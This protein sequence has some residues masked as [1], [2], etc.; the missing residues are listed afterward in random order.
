MATLYR[1]SCV[2]N[3]RLLF[4]EAMH[5]AAIPPPISDEERARRRAQCGGVEPQIEPLVTRPGNREVTF[6]MNLVPRKANVDLSGYRQAATFDFTLD[7]AA[8]PI[9]PRVVR[10]AAVEVHL[11]TV[12]DD[13]FRAGMQGARVGGFPHSV[14]DTRDAEGRVNRNTLVLIGTV[15]EWENDHDDSS[16][17][18]RMTGRDLR[19]IL[20]DSPLHVEALRRLDST[21]GADIVDVVRQI[22]CFHPFGDEF[23][24]EANEAEWPGGRFPT[25]LTDSALPRH[26]RGARGNAAH[27]RAAHQPAAGQ[28]NGQELTYWDAI[29]RMCFLVGAIPYFEAA[30]LRIRPARSVFAQMRAGV[31][32]NTATPFAG[33]RARDAGD[34]RPLSI[35][36]VA[37]GREIRSLK[38]TRK[39]GGH[40]KP[41]AIRAVSTDLDAA[42]GAAPVI[43]AQWP[44]RAQ[45]SAAQTPGSA[46]GHRTA[47]GR[48]QNAQAARTTR[49]APSGRQAQEEV[50]NVAVP[51]VRSVERL[52]EIARALFEEMGRQEFEGT[53]RT[54]ALASFGGDNRDPDML[55]L[56][57]GDALEL[58]TDARALSSRPPLVSTVADIA[59]R[60]AE[61]LERELTARLGSPALARAIV[62][63][64]RGEIVPVQDFFRVRSA[65]YDWSDQGI[66]IT[67]EFHNYFVHRYETGDVSTTA[68]S[69]TRRST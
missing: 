10:A 19:G 43:S 31:D 61:E 27:T 38:T 7:Y 15:D 26:R 30:V 63:T 8:L 17:T 32:P 1:P 55:R 21:Q 5:P 12:S 44:E 48:A 33:G 35:R 28:G 64:A 34:G 6:V 23:V 2:V 66:E 4:D 36:R 3:L 9:D 54:K 22:V 67:V 65:K 53:L 46:P 51:G 58:V 29:T 62:R 39:L 13:A 42:A 49:V 40:S 47:S 37:L 24:V 16:G 57:P 56:R 20:L 52:R 69:P 18:V 41:K 25:L 68:G 60:P 14:I 11:G 59:R 45:H 50:V